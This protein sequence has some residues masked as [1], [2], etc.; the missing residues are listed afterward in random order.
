MINGIPAEVIPKN[1]KWN[2]EWRVWHYTAQVGS[3]EEDFMNEIDSYQDHVQNYPCHI[4]DL[5]GTQEFVKVLEEAEIDIITLYGDLQRRMRVLKWLHHSNVEIARQWRDY[6]SEFSVEDIVSHPVWQDMGKLLKSKEDAWEAR[7]GK[8]MSEALL[9]CDLDGVLADFEKG[10]Q[11]LFP[12]DK[13]KTARSLWPRIKRAPAFFENLEWT[14]DGKILWDNIK[15]FEPI[16]MTGVPPG[17]WAREQKMNWLDREIGSVRVTFCRSRD[18]SIYKP[19]STPT[20]ILID[21]RNFL[22]EQWENSGGIFVH[23]TSTLDTVRQLQLIGFI[24][25]ID[26]EHLYE[27]L[28]MIDSDCCDLPDKGKERQL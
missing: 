8:E 24:E 9:F 5:I 11:R 17:S 28:G 7:G 22:R 25:E 18:K 2:G 6:Y 27:Q 20:A 12:G 10:V 21:D 3:W 15:D 1:V 14:K 4:E 23:H 19:E 16:I 26:Y 13:Q